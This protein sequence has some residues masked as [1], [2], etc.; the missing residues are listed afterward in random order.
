MASSCVLARL[1]TIVAIAVIMAAVITGVTPIHAL[2]SPVSCGWTQFQDPA[3]TT[4]GNPSLYSVGRSGPGDV[5]A[6]EAD[7]KFVDHFDGRSWSA[8]PLADFGISASVGSPFDAWAG[9]AEHWDGSQWTRTEM[10]GPLV[11][12]RPGHAWAGGPLINPGT[13]Y[14]AE[15]SAANQQWSSSQSLPTPANRNAYL[16]G[17]AD[18]TSTSSW[19]AGYTDNSGGPNVAFVD[20]WNGVSWQASPVQSP[21]TVATKINAIAALSDTDVW[22][23]GERWDS[24][25]YGG[26]SIVG[27]TEHWDGASWTVMPNVP[28]QAL[29]LSAVASNDVWASGR[30]DSSQPA[31]VAHWDGTSWTQIVTPVPPTNQGEL[32]GITAGPGGD[33]WAVGDDLSTPASFG[34]HPILE[35]Y[36][37]S[38]ASTALRVSSNFGRSATVGRQGAPV[39]LTLG[40][41]GGG[42]ISIVQVSLT[43]SCGSASATSLPCPKPDAGV[44]PIDGTG[45][46]R[47]GSACAGRSF[48]VTQVTGSSDGTLNI[49]PSSG[50]N[51]VIPSGATCVVDL[52]YSVARLPAMDSEAGTPGWQTSQLAYASGSVPGSTSAGLTAFQSSDLTV[53]PPP[54]VSS[55]Q[56]VSGQAAGGTAVTIS[57]SGFF[58]GTTVCQ[59]SAITFGTSAADPGAFAGCSDTSITVPSPARAVGT[60]DV[61]VTTPGGVS[62]TTSN[63]RYVFSPV[64]TV[65]S[66]APNFGPVSG[67]TTVVISGSGFFAGTTACRVSAISFGVTAASPATFTGCT[68]T[69]ITGSSPAAAGGTQD[70]AVTTTGGTSATNS[71]DRFTYGPAPTITGVYPVAGPVT[72]GATVSLSGTG[73]FGGTTSCQVS[74][75]SFGGT[76]A[77]PASFSNCS[78]TSIQVTSPAHSAG[79]VDVVVTTPVGSSA[80]SAADQFLYAAQPTVTSV[81]PNAGSTAGGTTVTIAGAGFAAGTSACQVSAVTFG[82]SA[83]TVLNPCTDT[84]ITVLSPPHSA[85]VVDVIVTTNGGGG[86]AANAGDVYR[87]ANPASSVV[88]TRQYHLAGSDGSTW[89][90][91]DPAAL[92]LSVSPIADSTALLGANADLWTANTGFNQDLAIFVSDNNGADQL[93]AWK[94]SGGFAGT[95]SPNAA[96]VRATFPVVRGHSYVFKLKWKTNK[97]AGGATIYAGAGPIDGRYSPTRLSAEMMPSSAVT[98]AASHQQYSLINSDGTTWQVMDQ[99]RLQVTLAPTAD[100]T[101][102]V[103]GN[104]DLWTETSTYNQDL[105]IFVSD[106]GAASQLVAWK[107]SGGFAGTFSPNAAYVEGK[108]AMAAGH[109]YV[110][111]LEWKT[112]RAA[113]GATIHAGAGPIGGLFSPTRLSANVLESGAVTDATST[114]QYSLVNSDGANWQP[115]D[116]GKFDLAQTP[117]RD[118]TAVVGGNVDLWTGS[119]GFNQDVGIFVSDDGGPD[120]LVAWKESGGFAGTASPNA[121]FVQVNYPMTAGHTYDFKL[122]WKTN[123]P[124]NSAVIFAGAGPI[125]GQF[126]PTRLAVEISG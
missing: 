43:P 123:R 49:A 79:T 36:S 60:V 37:C 20:H 15:W 88:S 62:A 77:N 97:L 108:Y 41:T 104:S 102:V 23:A 35:H 115:V 2:A 44:V 8:M 25:P 95:Y 122:K 48:N 73:F 125:G 82:G 107:E 12:S 111:R 24:G 14:I 7:D 16:K 103:G 121:A 84:S 52:T 31:A 106:N 30:G 27:L 75:I 47:A 29:S 119:R 21:G 117:T 69:S 81:S 57:G 13:P 100:A 105:A 66:V 54:I 33:V 93:V 51:V 65:T 64:P 6:A 90:D 10:A 89:S 101:V 114:R 116:A 92:I 78:G 110:F 3:P 76:A 19:V 11:G 126:S 26:A 70:V 59:V 74:G 83:A 53:Y 39:A 91:I 45:T 56:P 71:G 28:M 55:I 98:D 9:S 61:A 34:S 18:V 38:T 94:E 109:S 86:S 87:Y 5:W 22:I 85:A 50:T 112:N 4:S 118:V 124:A 46:G 42:D 72:G 17:I 99:N 58:A 32:W 96:F 113:R 1:A 80:T 40:A 67:G 120:L 63:D 68:D